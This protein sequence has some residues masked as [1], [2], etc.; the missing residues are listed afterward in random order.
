MG[1]SWGELLLR[2]SAPEIYRPEVVAKAGKQGVVMSAR[3]ENGGAL[4][5]PRRFLKSQEQAGGCRP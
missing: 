5:R 1:C 3:E 4:S 2:I